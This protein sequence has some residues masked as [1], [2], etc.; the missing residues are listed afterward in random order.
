MRLKL[1]VTTLF[2]KKKKE[3]IK[4]ILEEKYTETNIIIYFLQFNIFRIMSRW[5]YSETGSSSAALFS[6]FA[7]R[8]LFRRFASDKRQKPIFIRR[9]KLMLRNTRMAIRKM[10]SRSFYGKR[11]HNLNSFLG[12]YIYLFFFL[13]FEKVL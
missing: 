7:S 13:Q 2:L 10:L 1:E 5:H 4:K 12:G 9:A 8:S 6:L 3:K 11:L